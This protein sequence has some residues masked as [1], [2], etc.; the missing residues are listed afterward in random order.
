[1][2]AA[3]GHSGAV[4][5]LALLPGGHMLVSVSN[6]QTVRTWDLAGRGMAVKTRRLPDRQLET[7]W[8]ALARTDGRGAFDA[9]A[10]LTA[11]PEQT[12]TLFRSRLKPAQSPNGPRIAELVAQTS[13]AKYAVRE[14]ATR[15]LA[16]LG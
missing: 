8:S 2:A 10:D 11:S 3:G 16:R 4:N 5:G 15:A 1:M 13:D 14:Q 6:D 9:M 12:L 7:C